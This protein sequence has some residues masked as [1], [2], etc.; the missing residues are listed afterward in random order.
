MTKRF[1]VLSLFVFS[2]S[3]CELHSDLGDDQVVAGVNF[4]TLFAKPTVSE[5]NAVKID[6]SSREYPAQDV[7]VEYQEAVQLGE[8]AGTLKIVSHRVGGVKHY[9]AMIAATGLHSRQAPM[10]VY[11]H[12]GDSGV[13]IDNEVQLVLSFFA[14]IAHD[15]VIVIP[16]F[17]NEKLSYKSTTWQSEGPASPWDR[18]VD[19]VLS[20]LNVVQ[21]LELGADPERVGVLGF[22]RGAGVGMLMAAR[23]EK[24][25]MVLDFFGPTDFFGTFVQDVS[26][27]YLLGD[28]RDLPGLDYLGAEILQPYRDGEISLEEIRLELIR[29]SPVLFVDR[30]GQLQLHHGTADSIVPVSQA[31]SMIE[32]MEN[33][34]KTSPDFQAYLYEGGDHNPLTL[35]GSLE[36]AKTFLLSLRDQ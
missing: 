21:T 17:R 7:L 3:G 29:R 15:F 14:D 26:R 5:I 18:D 34:G 4:N 11:A 12:G 10:L 9:A 30:I 20:F 25:D 36:R 24:I 6:W 13:S 19:D 32:A 28:P 35:D 1:F 16:S 23:D 33:A 27:E 2:L 31:E 8:K 22:S